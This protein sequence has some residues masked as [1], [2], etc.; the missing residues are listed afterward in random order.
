MAAWRRKPLKK[1]KKKF[2]QIPTPHGANGTNSASAAKSVFS[3]P[4]SLSFT[5]I[6]F[7]LNT[8]SQ[9]QKFP[10][11]LG[12]NSGKMPKHL[13]NLHRVHFI[14]KK[15]FCWRTLFCIYSIQ[16]VPFTVY[17]TNPFLLTQ[18]LHGGLHCIPIN[19]YDTMKYSMIHNL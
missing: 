1:K 8:V 12:R 16:V 7:S 3:S 10:E 9:K 5:S 2:R 17:I 13:F 11:I 6:T 19:K 18:I 4:P 15:I 14:C